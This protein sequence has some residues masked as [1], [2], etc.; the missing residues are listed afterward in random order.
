[1]EEYNVGDERSGDP[2]MSWVVGDGRST[3]FWSDK[4]LLPEPLHEC[5]TGPN[6]QGVEESR[7]CEFW[8]NGRGWMLEKILPF[9]SS[10]DKTATCSRGY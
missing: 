4:L 3:R 5:V 2:R 10:R 7:V 9:C 1:M 6:Q 8:Q